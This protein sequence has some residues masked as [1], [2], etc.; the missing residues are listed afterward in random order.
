MQELEALKANDT[1]KI[2][3]LK[4]VVDEE[5]GK[6]FKEPEVEPLYT[7]FN[8]LDDALGGLEGGDMIVV[9]ARPAVGKSALV[10]QISMKLAKQN[11]RVAYYNLE[12]SDNKSI[13]L[14]R[15]KYLFMLFGFSKSG[16]YTIINLSPSF[17]PAIFSL[18]SINL[19][20]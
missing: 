19:N 6:Y 12:M 9:A 17:K 5:Q 16:T 2:R 15:N 8:R 4:D 14:N 18:K 7:G 11:K 20:P 13:I 3:P 1:V 10:T